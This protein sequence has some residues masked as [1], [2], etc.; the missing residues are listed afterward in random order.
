MHSIFTNN[1]KI[2][3]KAK[4]IRQHGQKKKYSFDIN[5]LNARLDTIQAAVLLE[6]IKIFPST[7]NRK[8]KIFE[9]Y[10]SLLKNEGNIKFLTIKKHYFSCYPSFNILAKKEINLETF[11]K[12][13]YTNYNILSK[14]N[15]RSKKYSKIIK[16]DFI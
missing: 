16:A 5:G 11:T 2:Y 8:K 1:K 10:I 7:I 3:L 4:Q 14:A 9:R 15:Y 6:K 13:K 12:K